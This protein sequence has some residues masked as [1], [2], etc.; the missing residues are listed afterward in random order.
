MNTTPL[1]D[2]K[3]IIPARY[4]S[5]RFPGKPL[6]DLAGKPMLQH[7]WECANKTQASEIIIATDDNRIREAAEQFGAQV[8]ITDANHP[9]GTDRLGEVCKKYHWQDD[10][11]VVNLQGDE[12]LTPACILQ[13]VANNLARYAKAGMATLSTP[14]QSV[15]D[16]FNPNV[17]KVVTDK[18][19]FALYFSRAPIP[20]NRDSGS[21][22]SD[23]H[24]RQY[25]RHLGIYAYRVG[26][27]RSYGLM[28]PCHLEQ[29]E[30]LE[31]LRALYNGVAIHV[32]VACELPGPGIDTPEDLIRI[33][34]LLFHE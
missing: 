15:S 20:W 32:D 29:A 6:A 5:T 26:F 10:D 14:I 23:Q 31:Q 22:I 2:F 1:P 19:G 9:T 8:C 3:I 12:P 24:A 27:L 11:I 28:K 33:R 17:V 4:A 30:K 25:Q 34:E 16:V 13:Q 18:N 21:A 7:A